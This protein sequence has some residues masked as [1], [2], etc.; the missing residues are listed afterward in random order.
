MTTSPLQTAGRFVGQS[1]KRKEDPR[2]VTGHGRYVDDVTVPGMLHAAFLRSDVARGRIT[3]LDVAAARECSGVHAVLTAADLND[4]PAGP[5]LPSMFADG[6]QGISAP[7]RPLADGDVRFVGDPI[8][9]VVADSR[10]VAEDA[11]ELIEVE[12]EPL[13]AVVDFERA[14]DDTENLVHPEL[15]SNIASTM[16]TPPDAALDEA[17]SRAAHV[18]TETFYQQ[19]QTPTPMETRG[20]VA[21]WDPYA[22]ALRVWMSSQ[23][24]HEVRRTCARILG[25]AE[26]RVRV[27]Q[28]DVGGGFGQKY[29]MPRDE[30]T[31]VLA[32]HLLGRPVKWIEDRRENLLSSNHARRDRATVT[33]GVDADGRI[34]GARIEH[35]ED[36]GAYANGGTGGTGMFVAMMFPG[37]Y[38]I[39][40]LGWSTT[41]VWTNTCGRGAYRGPWMMETVAREEMMDVVARAIGLDPLEFR[42]RNVIGR[43]ELPYATASGMVYEHVSPSETL[44]QAASLIDYDGF[45]S[46]QAEA[47]A[48]GRYLGVGLGLYIEPQAGMG[49]LGV[50]AANV[51]VEPDGT[52]N[53][54]VGSGSHG[55]SLETTV[56][57][58]VAEHLGVDID[59]VAVHQGDTDVAPFGGGTGGSRSGPILSPAA[60]QAALE[61]RD[62]A[63]RIAAHLMEAAPDDLEIDGGVI[64]VRGTPARSTTLA[65]VATTAYQ[66]SD[67]LP[68]GME[69]GLEVISRY[70]APPV[71]YSNAC[72]ACTCEVDAATGH[73]TLTRYVV[74]EDCGVMINPMVVEGQIAGGVVQGI[75]G[76]LYEQIVYD[77]EGN[78]LTTTFLDYLVPTAAEVPVIEYGHVETPAATPGGYKG[79]GEGGAIGSV[80][81]VFN[82]VADALA[83]L[84]ARVN[85][86]PLGPSEVLAA[87]EAAPAR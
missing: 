59:A 6:S 79:M 78:P 2:L 41:A 32:S 75:G 63:I 34:V 87:I 19:R 83:P 13:T 37:P 8:A 27:V 56:A 16:A 20:I 76:V 77:D 72:H 25:V 30:M 31:V 68:P 57:Q 47:R 7:V 44:E 69:P 46:R 66:Q 4:R 12:Y 45:R 60:R 64:S 86:L 58:V 61:V 84:G 43:D 65:Q 3:R 29:F 15:G 21:H 48:N 51:R 5:M 36:S 52:V 9:L 74:S 70:K 23:N 18:V 53:V 33:V 54:F 17:L 11:C 81:A 42:R 55:Q 50:E 14:A 82:A 40:R 85:R 22:A 38:R 26:S 71:M 10:Y 67:L 80:P 28:Q 24:P 62:K 1:V 49:A 73:V 35:L 39:P